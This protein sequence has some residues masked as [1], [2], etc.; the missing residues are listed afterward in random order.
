MSFRIHPGEFES[1]GSLSRQSSL[2]RGPSL[3]RTAS[4]DNRPIVNNFVDVPTA[5]PVIAPIVQPSEP[6]INSN[7]FQ[8]VHQYDYSYKDLAY[9]PLVTTLEDRKRWILELEQTVKNPS[10]RLGI[11]L[12][13]AN[14][15]TLNNLDTTNSKQA[16]DLLAD[17]AYAII[18]DKQEGLLPLLEE[19]MADMFHLGQCV[20]GRTTRLWQLILL[21]QKKEDKV[22]EK[23]E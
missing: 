22:E 12:I 15:G 8:D 16:E 19:Q 9:T 11:H 20:Q 13:Y 17:L 5:P 6:V 18:H 3:I 1:I 14:A 7:L 4:I 23:N 10:A 21:I 2:S